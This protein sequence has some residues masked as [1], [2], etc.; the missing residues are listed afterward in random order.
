M[1]DARFDAVARLAGQSNRRSALRLLA[2]SGLGIAVL[3]SITGDADAK[4]VNPD[5]KCKKK[6]SYCEILV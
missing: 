6:K 4:C 3:S 1:D 5:Q 2:A